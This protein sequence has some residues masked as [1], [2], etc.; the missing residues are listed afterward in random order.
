MAKDKRRW[1]TLC[2]GLFHI[3]LALALGCWLYWITGARLELHGKEGDPWQKFSVLYLDTLLLA[4]TFGF[5]ALLCYFGFRAGR[6]YVGV[7]W[8]VLL[9]LAMADAIILLIAGDLWLGGAKLLIYG[10]LLR[11]AII[12]FREDRR[13]RSLR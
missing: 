12:G 11:W 5:A 7:L 2:V 13:K 10:Y 6:G 8:L 1:Q 9:F 4:M 3:I